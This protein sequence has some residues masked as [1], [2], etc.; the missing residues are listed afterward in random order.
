MAPIVAL[1][2][3]LAYVGVD[4]DA[5][6]AAT[7]SGM[8]DA[9][10]DEIRT[11]AKRD[12]EGD[13]VDY[14]EVIRIDRKT[15]FYLTHVPVDEDRAITITPQLFDG[16]ELEALSAA[17]WRLEDAARG[18][19]RISAVVATLVGGM[20]DNGDRWRERHRRF[21]PGPE[22]LRVTWS[23]TGAISA[24]LRFATLEWLKERWRATDIDRH[25]AGYQT[26][27]DAETYFQGLIGTIPPAVGR[28]VLAAWQPTNGGVI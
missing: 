8:L 9:I 11:L 21:D 10:S 25:L 3:A 2:D 5:P 16:T 4:P 1:E 27:R 24:A 26:G 20:P 12:L 22:Y 7:V 6:E 13:G 18:R 28:A 14:D 17:Q 23:T 19:I 15:E